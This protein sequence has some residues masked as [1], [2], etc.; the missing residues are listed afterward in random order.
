MP[1]FMQAVAEH[2]KVNILEATGASFADTAA[3]RGVEVT[4]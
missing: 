1:R 4:G 3:A 2:I